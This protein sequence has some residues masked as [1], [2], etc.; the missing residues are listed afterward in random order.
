M[1]QW[2]WGLPQNLA[3]VF[4]YLF[5][6]KENRGSS[7]RCAKLAFWDRLDSMSLGMFLFIGK[8]EGIRIIKHEYGHSIQSMI[9]GPFYLIVAGIPSLLWCHVPFLAASWKRG[10]V[11]YFSRYPESWADRLGY[12][13]KEEV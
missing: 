2:T 4:V 10:K 12:A 6:K 13:D 11:S 8:G 9:L 7:Y 1:I 3:G 5:Q